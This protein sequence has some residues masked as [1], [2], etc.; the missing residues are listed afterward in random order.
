MNFIRKNKFTIIAIGVFLILVFLAFQVKNIF[1]PAAGNAFYG[2]R[3]N[4]MD[5]VEITSS[6][7]DKI[8]T[9]LAEADITDTSKVEVAGKI[10]KVTITIKD[11]AGRDAAKELGGKVL[12]NLTKEEKDF[13]DVQ[14]FI[15]KKI[16]SG[17][18]PIIGYHHHAKEGFSW[19]KDRTG[20]E[21]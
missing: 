8:T 15:Q 3:L 13:Y 2:S 14:L 21:E 10:I 11:D 18:F 12:D 1:F 6:K 5:E 20:S 9:A 7:K 19:T 4:G 17:E 16:E